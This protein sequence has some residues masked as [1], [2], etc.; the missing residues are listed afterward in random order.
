MNIYLTVVILS[1]AP[2][3]SVDE[4]SAGDTCRGESSCHGCCHSL[5]LDYAGDCRVNGDQNCDA[6]GRKLHVDC[7]ADQCGG[8][9]GRY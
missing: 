5:S 3:L 1:L 7:K 4:V 6:K 2:L 9:Q 8:A